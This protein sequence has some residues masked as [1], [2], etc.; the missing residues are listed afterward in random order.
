VVSTAASQCQGPGF[1]S[2]LGSLTVWSLQILPVSAWV[3][4]GNSGILLQSKDVRGRFIG[5]PKLPIVFQDMF[6][7]D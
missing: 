3:S 6:K 7:G 2:R 5:H 4:S 1:D